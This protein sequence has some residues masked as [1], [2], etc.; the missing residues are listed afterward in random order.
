MV[1]RNF[2][3]SCLDITGEATPDP[4]FVQAHGKF[5]LT[6]TGNNRVP[7]WDAPS[8]MHFYD[9]ANR[10]PVFRANPFSRVG[11]RLWAPELH[12][13]RGRWY[14][15]FA[16]AHSSQGNRSHRMYV[17]GGPPESKDP[18]KGPWELLGPIKGMDQRQWAIDGTVFEI[19]GT[20]Y[21]CY[22]GWPRKAD[23]TWED[24][25]E[26][27]QQLFIMRLKDPVTADSEPVCIVRAV[28][29]W[30]RS[31]DRAIVEGPQWLVHPDGQRWS[32]LAYSCGASW[33]K[34]YK[35]ATIK[36]LAGHDPLSAFAWHKSFRPLLQN[37]ED[38]KGPYGPG[39]GCFLN[40]GGETVA[41][42]HATDRETDGNQNRRCRMQRVR[43]LR[44]GPDM[45]GCVGAVTDVE[46]FLREGPAVDDGEGEEAE[47][48]KKEELRSLLHALTRR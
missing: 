39:H 5:Y 11:E 36:Y 15:Y 23:G 30:E 2:N 40:A 13:L 21:F 35:M 1:I 22:S 8:L 31:G 26:S 32:G 18:H 44:E 27:T 48:G 3:T 16:A 29:P 9:R 37:R 20:L 19:D 41:L 17:L 46:G 42:F 10:G 4:F 34:D 25:N 6:F 12:A 43:W 45:G 47:E 7:M 33:T 28:E 38:G 14:I 24:R